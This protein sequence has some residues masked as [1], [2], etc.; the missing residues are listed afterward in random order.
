LQYPE[1]F[2]GEGLSVCFCQM[3]DHMLSENDGTAPG[4]ERQALAD[5]PDEIN[6]WSSGTVKVDP[7][8]QRARSAADIQSEVSVRQTRKK[9]ER[10]LP[11]QPVVK[12]T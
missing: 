4:P 1:A 11:R 5:I 3:L 2:L 6:L 7:A 8:W 12:G 9:G 10:A